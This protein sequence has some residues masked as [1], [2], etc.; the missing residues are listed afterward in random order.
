VRL[1]E[2]AAPDLY[3]IESELVGNH[4]HETFD[5]KDALHRSNAP[6]WTLRAF[7][8]EQAIRLAIVMRDAIRPDDRLPRGHGFQSSANRP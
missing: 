8:G 4:V 5:N 7:I 6:V 2:V 3:R 1:D